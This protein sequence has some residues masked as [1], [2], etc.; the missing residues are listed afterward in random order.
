VSPNYYGPS[1]SNIRSFTGNPIGINSS[2]IENSLSIVPN[3]TEQ[4]FMIRYTSD[5][6]GSMQV[7]LHN[8][9]GEIIYH[10]QIQK[11]SGEYTKKIDLS[12]QA[13]GIY[14][15]EIVTDGEHL[16]KKIIRE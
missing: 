8:T 4:E 9:L 13:K 7:V 6:P 14:F 10:E 16:S 1:Y 5:K 2:S 3:P 12:K 15:L 11:F